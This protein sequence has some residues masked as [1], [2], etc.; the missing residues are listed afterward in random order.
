MLLATRIR[1]PLGSKNR[2]RNRSDISGGRRYKGRTKAVEVMRL[3]VHSEAREE[4]LQTVSFYDA[5]VPG[6]GL[7]F[8]TEIDRCQ[9]ALLETPLIGHPYGRRLR[10]FTVGAS[11]PTQSCMRFSRMYY[12]YW[13]TLMARGAQ[14]I[15]EHGP[16]ANNRFERSRGVSSVSQGGNG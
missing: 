15:G 11:F 2:E 12:L 14:A 13:R 10:K 4:S 16:S 3:E 9:K 7:R 8:I 5:Q 6:L 1:K